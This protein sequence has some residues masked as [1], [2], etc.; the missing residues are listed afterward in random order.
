[1]N[2]D[3]DDPDDEEAVIIAVAAAEAMMRWAGDE[4]KRGRGSE[5]E[6]N[7]LSPHGPSN[8]QPP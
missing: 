7:F 1:M 2:D 8:L 4:R 5:A 3:S 6:T